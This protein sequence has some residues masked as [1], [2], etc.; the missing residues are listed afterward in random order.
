MENANDPAD[1]ADDFRSDSSDRYRVRFTYS[2][3]IQNDGTV[4]GRG[5]GSYQSATWHLEGQNGTSGP[6]N[7][8]PPIE[9]GPFDVKITGHARDG[10]VRL[11]FH[12]NAREH[13]DEMD[14]G[15]DYK[16]FET[17]SRYVQDSLDLVQGNDGIVVNQENP[18]IRPLRKNERTGPDTDRRVI[19]HEWQISIRPPPPPVNPGGG[20]GP[21]TAP[22]PGAPNTSICTIDGTARGDR[23]VGTPENDVIC[24]FGGDDV[25]RGRGGHDIVFGASGDD[26]ITG[27]G[28]LDSLLGNAG[29]DLLLA[30]DGKRDFVSGGPGTD[31]ARFDRGRDRLRSVERRN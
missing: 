5:D 20:R 24:G 11:R 4:L 12:L 19:L 27:G 30:R 23:L 21:G 22:G 14:C 18:A 26:R 7:C 16:A 6:F 17:S 2:F 29:G 13:N 3:R 15:G 9:A 1:G 10:R 25:I 31:A 28:G 8:D